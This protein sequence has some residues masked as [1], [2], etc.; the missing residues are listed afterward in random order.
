MRKIVLFALV[1][2]TTA[3]AEEG[4]L[5]LFGRVASGAAGMVAKTAGQSYSDAAE[6]HANEDPENAEAIRSKAKVRIDAL[7]SAEEKSFEA[8]KTGKK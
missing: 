5:G 6:K 2:S 7:K 8:A 3:Y 1:F 4:G